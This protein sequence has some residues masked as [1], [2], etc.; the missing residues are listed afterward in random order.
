MPEAG[1]RPRV[2]ALDIDGTLLKWVERR[3]YHARGDQPRR[4]GRRT[5]GARR[6]RARRAGQ[7]P[8]AARHDQRRRPARAAH[9]R[10]GAAL[11]GG[12]QRGRRL[13]LPAARGRP[14][15]DVRRPG[16][17]PAGARGTTPTRWS[18]SRS[19]ASGT[20]SAATSPDGRALRGDAAHRSR[21]A[22]RRAGQPRDHPRPPTPPPRSSSRWVPGSACTA[23]TTSSAGPP[24][25]TWPRSGSRRR[26]ACSW[27]STSSALDAADVLAIGDGRNDLEMLPLGRPRGRDGAGGPGG[28]RRRRREHRQRPRRRRRRSRSTA[29]SGSSG[30]RCERPPGRGGHRAAPAPAVDPR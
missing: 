9:Q 15:G 27:S 16:R 2:V 13:P 5:P 12:Q 21:R 10:L 6:R 18:R 19:G 29:G 4:A 7:R 14:R 30:G 24:G 22:R 8:L 1:W 28:A 11:G 23:P 26:P 3:R 20:G 17:G 25:S